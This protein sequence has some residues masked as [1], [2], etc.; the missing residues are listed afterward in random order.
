MLPQGGASLPWTNI[1]VFSLLTF[2]K[3]SKLQIY[4]D[5]YA[6]STKVSY[7]LAE[8]LAIIIHN[9]ISRRMYEKTN[10]PI[11]SCSKE[12]GE[13][14]G[15]KTFHLL[16]LKKAV[17][18]KTIQ[19]SNGKPDTIH[20]PEEEIRPTVHEFLKRASEFDKHQ[21]KN[22]DGWCIL[23]PSFLH[24]LKKLPNF[25]S[26]GLLPIRDVKKFL[27]QYI[28]LKGS[29]VNDQENSMIVNIKNDPLGKIF[30]VNKFHRIQTLKFILANIRLVNNKDSSTQTMQLERDGG[31]EPMEP[32]AEPQVIRQ[33]DSQNT[34]NQRD[35]G[36]IVLINQSGDTSG[37]PSLQITISLSRLLSLQPGQ[38]ITTKLPGHLLTR[39]ETGYYQILRLD[40]TSNEGHSATTV[41]ITP[42]NSTQTSPPE[43]LD[44][45]LSS[46]QGA[47]QNQVQHSSTFTIPQRAGVVFRANR[48]MHHASPPQVRPNT[49]TNNETEENNPYKTVVENIE[50]LPG[51]RNNL[52]S[53]QYSHPPYTQYPSEEIHCTNETECRHDPNRDTLLCHEK[54]INSSDEEMYEGEYEVDSSQ[55]DERPFQANGRGLL[56]SSPNDSD[57]EFLIPLELSKKEMIPGPLECLSSADSVYTST[58][59]DEVFGIHIPKFNKCS[60]CRQP[61]ES[62]L[63]ICKNC[64][65]IRKKWIKIK[66]AVKRKNLHVSLTSSTK[67]HLPTMLQKHKNKILCRNC[68]D[69][70]PDGRFIHRRAA[71]QGYCYT[72]AKSMW[73]K[74][75]YCPQCNLKIE[76]VI[77]S[78]K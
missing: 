9:I 7:S 35:D 78:Y 33:N 63:P 15:V 25:H 55:D 71:H 50:N 21:H 29:K 58:E 66:K 1:N 38:A 3:E 31:Q 28:S 41:Q 62:K 11:I 34:G 54:T 17:L 73:K 23:K 68:N 76:R 22:H 60:L 64:W 42:G 59:H 37:Q 13:A 16:E 19:V 5:K 12:L 30:G 6:S 75:D 70:A 36:R 8:V 20:L 44:Q 53:N 65:T 40:S 74:D 48:S 32:S 24:L 52:E 56:Y 57:S 10:I 61:N 46:H 27:D 77:K 43:S 2:E 51:R 47:V 67:T 72:C 26:Q 69:R 14:I 49:S 45:Q 4:I 39:S 18:S